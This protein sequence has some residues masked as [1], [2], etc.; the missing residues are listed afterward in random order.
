MDVTNGRL[1]SRK[2]LRVWEAFKLGVGR[3]GGL[4]CGLGA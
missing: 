3:V 1:L 2:N 4:G